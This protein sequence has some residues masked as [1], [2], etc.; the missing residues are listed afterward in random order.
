MRT[1]LLCV[2][3]LCRFWTAAWRS[4]G[5]E[6]TNAR[7]CHVTCTKSRF[8]NV[9]FFFARPPPTNSRSIGHGYSRGAPK[10]LR[11]AYTLARPWVLLV[12]RVGL[13]DMGAVVRVVCLCAS[14]IGANTRPDLFSPRRKGFQY[15]KACEMIPKDLKKKGRNRRFEKIFR[16]I[17]RSILFETENDITVLKIL[18]N[19]GILAYFSP[20]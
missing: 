6:T 12:A 1:R 10:R 19:L 17:F 4:R 16:R 18:T 15:G 8:S 14:G 11:R 2:V 7:T 20:R 13:E 9:F 5:F 3:Q